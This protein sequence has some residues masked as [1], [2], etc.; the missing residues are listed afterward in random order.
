MVACYKAKENQEW[1]ENPWCSFLDSH[2]KIL[3]ETW[4][5]FFEIDHVVDDEN[6]LVSD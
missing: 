3:V 4:Y 6:Y 2:L 1:R 5:N